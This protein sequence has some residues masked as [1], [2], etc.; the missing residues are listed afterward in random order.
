MQEKNKKKKEQNRA[1]RKKENLSRVT[2]IN[3]IEGIGCKA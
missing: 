1:R 2:L 3:V